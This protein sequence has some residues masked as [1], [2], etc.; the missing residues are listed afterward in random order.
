MG[1]K[2]H[3]LPLME[4][5]HTLQG[6]GFHTGK[7][8]TFIRL[9]GCD[10]GCFWCDVKESWDSDLHPSISEDSIVN[11]ALNYKT[12]FVVITG[13][14]PT[15]HNLNGLVNKLKKENFY[16]AIE[17]AGTNPLPDNLDW[18]CFS[19]KKFK[20]PMDQIYHV[21]DELKV[22]IFQKSDLD[23]AL[24]HEKKMTNKNCNL[25]IQP[26]WSKKDKNLS[27]ILSFLEENPRWRLS[28]Q[29][30]KFLNIS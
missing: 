29:S 14:E 26:E 4:L 19:P 24:E 9:A 15:L 7:P 13:G 30:H 1:N 23:W 2:V 28:I 16:T 25:F 12:K 10:V 20:D 17:T 6:E 11:Q 22:I 3:K 21:A 8:A 27:Y 5:F 18:I